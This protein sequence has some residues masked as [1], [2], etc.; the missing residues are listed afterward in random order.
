MNWHSLR[1]I[2]TSFVK[3]VFTWNTHTRRANTSFIVLSIIQCVLNTWKRR[4]WELKSKKRVHTRIESVCVCVCSMFIKYSVLSQVRESREK[5][6]RCGRIEKQER[7]ISWILFLES[8]KAINCMC[9][10][11]V[12][13]CVECDSPICSTHEP[14]H[15]L[16]L[17]NKYK[18]ARQEVQRGCRWQSHVAYSIMIKV[19]ICNRVLHL[20]F[21]RRISFFS[22]FWFVVHG[23][24]F[25]INWNIREVNRCRRKKVVNCV[26]SAAVYSFHLLSSHIVAY[27]RQIV[28]D[29]LNSYVWVVVVGVYEIHTIS[30]TNAD[31]VNI[32]KS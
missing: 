12:Y 2:E 21:V 27:N 23:L 20:H 28:C 4:N 30:T 22:F 29:P 17:R 31:P 9:R 32:T 24:W 14:R 7:R 19:I 26:H 15:D 25:Q 13:V 1:K 6:K 16:L 3:H 10:N 11:F 8:N 5:K 18:V